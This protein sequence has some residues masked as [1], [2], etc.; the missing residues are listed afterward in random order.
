MSF[1]FANQLAKKM[2]FSDKMPADLAVLG[3][4]PKSRN[5]KFRMMPSSYNLWENRVS[6]RRANCKIKNHSIK[7]AAQGPAGFAAKFFSLF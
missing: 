7:M 4:T 3:N 6:N 1:E 2:D 5:A